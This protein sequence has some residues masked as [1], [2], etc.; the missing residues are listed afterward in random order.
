M[1]I[2]HAELD[3]RR[4]YSVWHR[5][6]PEHRREMKSGQR[7]ALSHYLDWESMPKGAALD[8]GCGM[9]FTLEMLGDLGF[10]PAIG[11]DR[12]AGQIEICRKHGLQAIRTDDLAEVARAWPGKFKIITAFDFIEHMPGAAALELL[13]KVYAMLDDD[14]V[15]VCTVPNATSALAER[16][17]YIDFTHFESFTEHSLDFLLH[18]SGFSRIEVRDA[19]PD[20]LRRPPWVFVRPRTFLVWINRV[21]ARAFRRW[22]CRVELGIEGRD[23]PLSLNLLGI[24]RK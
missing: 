13:R 4:H 5:D 1:T 12:D 6:T 7:R 19:D 22:Q 3:Y 17:R 23:V 9:G 14:G 15:F 8:L 11:M 2:D 10:S 16:W 18:N 20:F 21:M 24:A